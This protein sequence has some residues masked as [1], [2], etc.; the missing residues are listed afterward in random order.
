MCSWC[1]CHPFSL[2]IQNAMQ[3]ELIQVG[4]MSVNCAVVFSENGSALVIDPG[5]DAGKIR[6]VLEAHSATVEAYLLTHSHPDHTNALNELHQKYP[7]PVFIHSADYERAFSEISQIPPHYPVPKK[8]DAEFIHP[9]AS[10]H[11]H[12][13]SLRC[14]RSASASLPSVEWNIDGLRFQC[15]ETPGHTPGGVCY[16]FE[17]EGVCFTGDT[18]LKGGAARSSRRLGDRTARAQSFRM[19]ATLPPATRLIPGHGETTTLAEELQNNP[20]MKRALHGR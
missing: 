2:G 8:P 3:F 9:E 12:S 14:R 1:F 17:D 16:W 7:A 6:T 20:V 4:P 10:R 5:F 15:L 13:A 11:C 19:L 18:L